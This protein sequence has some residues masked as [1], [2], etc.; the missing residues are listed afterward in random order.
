VSFAIYATF[1][2][3]VVA[4]MLIPGP[5]VALIAATSLA[6]GQRAA[7]ATVAGTC[8]AMIPQLALTSLSMSALLE[9]AARAFA[10]LRWLGVAYLIW[11]AYR[12]FATPEVP[13]SASPQPRPLRALFLRGFLVSLS[14]PKTLLFFAAFFPQF[15]DPHGPIPTQLMLLSATFLLLAATIDSGWAL[16]T[17]RLSRLLRMSGKARDRLTGGLLLGAGLCS[18]LVRKH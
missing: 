7:L 10:V 2:V 14:N 6:F 9:G 17:A 3:S 15:L 5:N 8:A 12:A 1:V 16:M 18:A 11:L 4:L 13:L